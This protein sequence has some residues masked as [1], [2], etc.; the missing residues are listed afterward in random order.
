M[1]QVVPCFVF[2]LIHAEG[3]MFEFQGSEHIS[4][5]RGLSIKSLTP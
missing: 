1:V 2:G 5:W 4:E 3:S